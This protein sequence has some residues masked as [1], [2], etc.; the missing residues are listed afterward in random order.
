[1]QISQK[2]NK[3][4]TDFTIWGFHLIFKEKKKAK[5]K[6]RTQREMVDCSPLLKKDRNKRFKMKHFLT[7]KQARRIIGLFNTFRRNSTKWAFDDLFLYFIWKPNGLPR[8][9]NPLDFTEVVP[10]EEYDFFHDQNAV[11]AAHEQ[12][13]IDGINTAATN[14]F[15]LWINKTKIMNRSFDEKDTHFGKLPPAVSHFSAVMLHEFGHVLRARANRTTVETMLRQSPDIRTCYNEYQSRM[16]EA[17]TEKDRR[18][19][20]RISNEM[21]EWFADIFSKSFILYAFG[22]G[23]K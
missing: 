22:D 3:T 10:D 13:D 19:W 14:G 11:L 15:R 7:R 2:K 5:K 18:K 23:I 12:D 16:T 21:E 8:T 17:R 6:L 20:R 1:M 4:K 9:P